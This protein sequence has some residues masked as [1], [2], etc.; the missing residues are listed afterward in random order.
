MNKSAIAGVS[1]VT[2]AAAV[3]SSVSEQWWIRNAARPTP[4]NSV[5]K[6]AYPDNYSRLNRIFS[7]LIY[8]R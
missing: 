2:T 8:S 6:V 1:M 5:N 4:I 3:V 7:F